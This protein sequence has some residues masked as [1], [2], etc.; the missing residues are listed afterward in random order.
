MKW[1]PTKREALI[2]SLAIAVTIA[3]C[4][5]AVYYRDFLLKIDQF[6][7]LGC[8]I[9]NIFAGSIIIVPVPGLLV[10]FTLGSVLNP[11]IVGAVAGLGEAIGS[12]FV[13]LTGFAGRGAVR[14]INNALYTRFT[15]MFQRHGSKIVFFMA[16]IFNPV[17]YFFGIFVGMIRFG[18][19]KFFLLTLAGRIIKNMAVAYLGYFGLRAVLQWLGI[20]I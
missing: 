18:L 13:Y 19:T 4:V 7:Y 12:V 11:A 20:A 8:F 6:G 3:L 15:N 5:A 14:N 17:Y 1:R 9:I 16:A 10:T 2:G